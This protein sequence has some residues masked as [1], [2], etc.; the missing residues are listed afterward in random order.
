MHN[1]ANVIGGSGNDPITGD[2]WPNVL[3]GGAGNDSLGGKAS[4]DTLNGGTGND[5]LIGGTGLDTLNG[6]EGSDSIAGNEDGD[7]AY[8]NQGDVQGSDRE[9]RRDRVPRDSHA[10]AHGRA[11]GR[12]VLGGRRARAARAQADEAVCIG[13]AQVAQSYLRQDIVLEPRPNRGA[14]DPSRATAS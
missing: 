5:S 2:A 6:G 11:L 7:T 10:A 9:P 1:I 3:D 8:G 14:G 12:G 4:D 13:P